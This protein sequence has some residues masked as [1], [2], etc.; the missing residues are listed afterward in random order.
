MIIYKEN[1]YYAPKIQKQAHNKAIISKSDV[2]SNKVSLNNKYI[3]SKCNG[4]L[5]IKFFDFFQVF[6]LIKNKAYKLKLLKEQKIYN[7]FHILLQE[8]NIIK[9]GQVD[10]TT[11]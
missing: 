3:K 9:N 7:V 6:H 1:F 2:F 11:T 4:N 5:K 8:Y 10:K